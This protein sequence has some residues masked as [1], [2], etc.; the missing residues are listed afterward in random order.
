M[1]Q[2][3][4]YCVLPLY[5]VSGLMQALRAFISGG[6]LAVQPFRSLSSGNRLDLP[7][8][9]SFISLVPTQLQRLL[10]QG[11]ATWL[12]QF[13][14]VLLGGAP[15]WPSLLGQ[16][17]SQGIPIAL[18]YGMTETA[19][20]VATLLPAEFLSDRNSAGRALPHARIEIWDETGEKLPPGQVGQICVYVRSLAHGYSQTSFGSQAVPADV[21]GWRGFLP[22]DVGYLDEQGYLTVVGRNNTQ[23]ITGGEKV[24]PEEVERVI[25][26]TGL[27]SDVCV[28]GPPN[29]N[30]GQVVT[31]LY[32][33]GAA[34]LDV[35]ELRQSIM[36][37][38]SKF[39]QPKHWIAV[40]S[41]PRNAQGKV[42]RQVALQLAEQRLN[43][44]Q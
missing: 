40:E 39:K 17:R 37:Q 34:D 33:P 4:A 10:D 11:E 41:L 43:E 14:A 9:N 20:Q 36:P 25:L 29:S 7:P 44:A 15:A 1:A 35:E 21:K 2:V 16:A 26:E 28:V 27:V 12:S 13:R 31:A 8:Q 6:K 32:M 19:A 3:H 24:F 22:G 5:H 38:L 18:T 30:W 42:N 23:I